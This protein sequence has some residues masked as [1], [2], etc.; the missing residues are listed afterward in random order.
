MTPENT[1]ST[2]ATFLL[3]L[4]Y[5]QYLK[6]RSYPLGRAMELHWLH[7]TINSLCH[8]FTLQQTVLS[9]FRCT[10]WKTFN[11][12]SM[13]LQFVLKQRASALPVCH[14]N[15]MITPTT[16]VTHRL[17]QWSAILQVT[18]VVSTNS[19][20]I[21]QPP[22]MCTLVSS[23]V[24]ISNIL[25]SVESLML[26]LILR[27]HWFIWRINFLCKFIVLFEVLKWVQYWS[28]QWWI[29]LEQWRSEQTSECWVVWFYSFQHSLCTQ[30]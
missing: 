15:P 27:Y 17:Y 26:D 21:T 28:S 24:M 6:E 19:T 23:A 29:L 12:K 30:L 13:A 14:F 5:I 20:D 25:I 16:S 3:I 9:N 22:T 1:H 11:P 7:S 4:N 18:V 10:N 8:I 2:A